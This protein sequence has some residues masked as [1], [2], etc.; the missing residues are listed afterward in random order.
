MQ[1]AAAA[2]EDAPAALE[3]TVA[4]ERN[5]R[6]IVFGNPNFVASIQEKERQP[7]RGASLI[8][9][10][11]VMNATRVERLSRAVA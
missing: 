9:K 5:N 3:A 2:E 11:G 10:T 1:M 8:R 6:A 4:T 7:K